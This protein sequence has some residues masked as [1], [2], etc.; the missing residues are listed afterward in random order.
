MGFTSYM[1]KHAQ[2]GMLKRA[3]EAAWTAGNCG[4]MVF[5]PLC[6]ALETGN[7]SRS[8]V[9][10]LIDDWLIAW[11]GVRHLSDRNLKRNRDY[12]A[13]RPNVALSP[14]LMDFQQQMEFIRHSS[15]LNGSDMLAKVKDA[16]FALMQDMIQFNEWA[17]SAGSLIDFDAA[18]Y[19]S[20]A[21]RR[22][23]KYWERTV[24]ELSKAMG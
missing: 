3:M 1:E 15:D 6:A 7:A 2:Q 8:D 12:H 17:K 5:L 10:R 13:V 20:E 11:S 18:K 4:G 9:E 24:R 16:G 21:V 23:Q 14:I 19:E 22:G